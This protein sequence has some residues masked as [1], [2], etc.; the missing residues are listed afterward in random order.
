MA[1]LRWYKM[2]ADALASPKL[3]VSS[4]GAKLL[5]WYILGRNAARAEDGFVPERELTYNAARPFT[6]EDS[7]ESHTQILKECVENDLIVFD[8]KKCGF[9]IKGW[10]EEWAPPESGASRQARYRKNKQTRDE[11]TGSDVTRDVTP[12]MGVEKVTPRREEKRIDKNR[13]EE[14]GLGGSKGGGSPPAAPVQ[15]NGKSKRKPPV[16]E[17]RSAAE[18]VVGKFN[19]YFGTRKRPETWIDPIGKA[20]AAGFTPLLMAGA[21]WGAWQTCED[22]P[23]V[24]ANFTPGSVLRLKSR[25]GK[26]TLAQ[27]LER[28]DELWANN[29]GHDVAP[30]RSDE[31][32]KTDDDRIREPGNPVHVAMRQ[33]FDAHGSDA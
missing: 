17:V 33:M 19:T 25:E 10:G 21:C 6:L 12:V 9:W 4:R 27:W 32:K 18:F 3:I 26:T 24:L 29:N 28:A 5:Y 30:W 8:A 1:G 14:T 15:R 13:K 22:S 2:A 7:E 31:K 20:L 23:E 16:A 11:V